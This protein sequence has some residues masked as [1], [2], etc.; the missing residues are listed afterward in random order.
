MRRAVPNVLRLWAAALVVGLTAMVGVASAATPPT[1]GVFQSTIT[2]F[3]P[4]ISERR[5]TGLLLTRSL[6][7][8]LL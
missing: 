8:Q 7:V 4:C 2:N 1:V 6:R 5:L 3:L